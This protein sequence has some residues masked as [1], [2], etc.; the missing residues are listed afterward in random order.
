MEE[1]IELA[2]KEGSSDKVYHAELKAE[3][4]GYVVNFAYGRRGN[5]LATGSKTKDPIEFDAAKSVYDKLIKSKVSKGYK[6]EGT[7]AEGIQVITDKKDTGVR[8]QLLNEIEEFNVDLYLQDDRYCMQEKNDGRRKLL[9]YGGST[10]IGVNKKGFETPVTIEMQTDLKRI[11]GACLLDG[12]DMGD[13]IRLF[14][15]ITF[16][17]SRYRDRYN[18]MKGIVPANLATLKIVETGWTTTEKVIMFNRL[19]LND[20]E[21]VVFKLVDAPY[22]PGRPSSGGPQLK[23]KF[24][25]SASCI[26]LSQ[27]KVKSSIAVGVLDDDGNMVE[28]GNVT[29]YPN[30]VTPIV[31]AIVEV[32]YLYYYPNGSLY[33][34]VLLDI[35]DDIDKNECLLSKL[36]TKAEN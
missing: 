20:A 36:K 18:M 1:N 17:N 29:V 19:K 4:D 11:S 12:E 14:D 33:Q 24:Y 22:E 21:G 16:P 9:Q 8:P 26:V 35:R 10:V 23:C 25:E 32:K 34:P 30:Q 3:D 31:D 7:D 13:H 5:T 28:V 2:F 6:P 15:M 27:S